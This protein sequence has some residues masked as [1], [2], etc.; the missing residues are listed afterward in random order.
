MKT[1]SKRSQHNTIPVAK[2]KIPDELRKSHNTTLTRCDM[3][4]N[5]DN[6][7]AQNTHMYNYMCNVMFRMMTKLQ[8]HHVAYIH[9]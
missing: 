7:T 9:L 3:E 8:I 1:F 5:V 6:T 4:Q 2:K